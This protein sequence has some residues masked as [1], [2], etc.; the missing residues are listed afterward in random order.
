[1][2]SWPVLVGP[3]FLDVSIETTLR[4]DNNTAVLCIP[5]SARQRMQPQIYIL[6]TDDCAPEVR[7]D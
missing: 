3:H 6:D 4:A 7:V 2:K 5:H 1:M